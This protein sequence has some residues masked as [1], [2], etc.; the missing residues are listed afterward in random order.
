MEEYGNKNTLYVLSFLKENKKFIIFP[1]K[2]K[3]ITFFSGIQT[4]SHLSHKTVRTH[5][6]EVSIHM[7]V[8]T[9][10][11]HIL[12]LHQRTKANKLEGHDIDVTKCFTTSMY[13]FYHKG[14]TLEFIHQIF[15]LPY[16][17][18][19]FDNNNYCLY[20]ISGVQ[21]FRRCPRRHV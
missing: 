12:I 1:V 8:H 9:Q 21:R 2:R 20:H 4:I 16:P 5:Q 17:D 18:F 15:P 10:Y 19:H 3:T 14:C 6:C 13:S 11:Q 7:N